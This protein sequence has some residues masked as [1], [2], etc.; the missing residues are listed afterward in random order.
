MVAVR[1]HNAVTPVGIALVL[2][3]VVGLAFVG[4]T[5]R[6][7]PASAEQTALYFVAVGLLAVFGVVAWLT[8]RPRS[9]EG[10]DLLRLAT[11]FGVVIGA[12]WIV[13]ILAGNLV[14]IDSAVTHAIYRAATAIAGFLPLVAGGIAAYRTG[15]VRSG[16]AVGFWSGLISGMI[17]FLMLMFVTYAFMGVLR[18]DP[19]TVQEYTC[20]TEH[21]LA[22]Y[23]VGDFLAAACAH[24][25]IVGATWCTL[26]GS[27]GGLA[28]AL[29]K[30][31][32]S[33]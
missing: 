2:G 1:T 6:S 27:L 18:H 33:A 31:S 3:S 17:G 22:T 29:L 19:Q 15:R 24:L 23:I 10:A 14:A 9:V 28:G 4:I 13:E 30:R 32:Q 8:T 25:V 20:S 7:Y 11:I 16:T 12:F 26:L 21:T 5:I